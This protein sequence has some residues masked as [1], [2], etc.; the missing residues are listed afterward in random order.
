MMT[1][2]DSKDS[3]CAAGRENK[4]K[5]LIKYGEF[6]SCKGAMSEILVPEG[7]REIDR[8]CDVTDQVKNHI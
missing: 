3:S 1:W 8:S 5:D 7:R 6:S 4:Q 2:G